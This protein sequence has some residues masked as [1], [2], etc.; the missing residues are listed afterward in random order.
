M[1]I[2]PEELMKKRQERRKNRLDKFK[3][4]REQTLRN[5]NCSNCFWLNRPWG[6]TP[7]KTCKR[8]DSARKHDKYKN[9]K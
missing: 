6:Q 1:A 8:F 4:S 7:C 2:P 3:Q 9:K 5:Q